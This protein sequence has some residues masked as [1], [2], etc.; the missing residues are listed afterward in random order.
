MRTGIVIFAH[1]SPVEAAND[2]VH[3]VTA[4]MSRRT[5]TAVESAFLECARP[6]CWLMRSKD[7]SS[8]ASNSIVV[9]PYFLTMGI[10]LRRDLPRIAD[11][12]RNIYKHV[13]I[14]IAE[15]LD[16]HP[17]LVDILSNEQNKPSML[18]RLLESHEIAHEVRHFTFEVPELNDLPYLPGQFCRLR[19]L[20]RQE[21]TRA[22]ST[23]SPPKGNRFELCLNLVEDGLFSPFLF[24]LQ[25]GDTVPMMRT[26]WAILPGANRQRLDS[27]SDGHRN[28][29]VSRNAAGVPRGG[30][31]REITLVFGVRY[32]PSLLYRDRV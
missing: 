24:D 13:S 17:A 14:D 25:P 20:W 18:A 28:C 26:V 8:K 4:E 7:W 30:G 29:S 16:G 6:S 11:E 21:V 15:P 3:A 9:V 31:D 12:L 32:E 2:A 22:Y 10:H 19:R 5:S 23:A 27:R 1:G